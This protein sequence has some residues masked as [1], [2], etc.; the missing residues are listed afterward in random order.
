MTEIVFPL[1]EDRRPRFAP[2]QRARYVPNNRSFGAFIRSD[3]M[4]DVTAEVARDIQAEAR[5]SVPPPR[6]D[7]DP[8][9]SAVRITVRRQAGMVKVAGN[10]RVKVEVTMSGPGAER[11]EFGYEAGGTR[12]RTLGKAGSKFGDLRHTESLG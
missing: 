8:K 9:A 4:R 12:Y 10:V 5:A 7:S 6:A 2:G 1:P 11:A 3:Q